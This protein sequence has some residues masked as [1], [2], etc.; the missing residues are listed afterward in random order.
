MRRFMNFICAAAVAVAP[1]IL[2]SCNPEDNTKESEAEKQ[3][4]AA[5]EEY[6][7]DVIY[8]IY[9]NLADAAF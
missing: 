4:K 7:P 5:V 3:L 9:G 6:V 1:F 8:E 2:V